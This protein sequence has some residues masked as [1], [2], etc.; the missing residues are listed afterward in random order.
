MQ[1]NINTIKEAARE[2]VSE[3]NAIPYSIVE[4][5]C[6]YDIDSIYELTDT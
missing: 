6:R 3:F 1:K 2:W 5:I 4:K